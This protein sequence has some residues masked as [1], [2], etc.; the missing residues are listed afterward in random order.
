MT[1]MRRNRRQRQHTRWV[2]LLEARCVLDSTVVFN[3]LMYY[4]RPE[5]GGAASEWIE[6]HNQMS[7]DVELS[8]WR[9]DGGV[10]YQ[11]PVG[12]IL[13]AGDYLVVAAD[14]T[15]LVDAV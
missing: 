4:P 15:Q 13:A 12:T 2:E 10:E 11:F 1:T 7:V 6:L 9:I 8:N 14:P 5:L 3:E